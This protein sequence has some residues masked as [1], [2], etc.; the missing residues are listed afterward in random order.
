MILSYP[1][2]LKDPIACKLKVKLFSLTPE[3]LPPP[4]SR[5]FL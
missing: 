3:S 5:L 2:Y 4:A 1:N